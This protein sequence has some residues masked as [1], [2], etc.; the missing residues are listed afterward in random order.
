MKSLQRAGIGDKG[1]PAPEL[2]DAGAPW[3]LAVQQAGRDGHEFHILALF[4]KKRLACVPTGPAS[5]EDQNARQLLIRGYA[6]SRGQRPCLRGQ[7]A[8]IR[9]GA[10]YDA[11]HRFEGKRDFAFSRH[12]EIKPPSRQ[13]I[14]LLTD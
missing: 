7:F 11:L 9:V 12:L 6:Q 3:G 14:L 10:V 1:P 8:V 2:Q 4:A 13:F 5:K